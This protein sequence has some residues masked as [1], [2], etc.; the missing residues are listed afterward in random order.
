MWGRKGGAAGNS[1]GIGKSQERLEARQGAK[2]R[3]WKGR[4][5]G[6][7]RLREGRKD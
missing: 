5:L 3:E 7:M 2:G 1:L 6:E 4:R